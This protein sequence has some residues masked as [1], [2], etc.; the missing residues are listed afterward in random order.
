MT[1]FSI[2]SPQ[3]ARRASTPIGR[4]QRRVDFDMT[5]D[6]LQS[7][8]PQVRF[9]AS[10]TK[11]PLSLS[12]LAATPSND[13]GVDRNDGEFALLA[14]DEVILPR[15]SFRTCVHVNSC[16]KVS[17]THYFNHSLQ[18]RIRIPGSSITDKTIER[19]ENANQPV[20]LSN[21]SFG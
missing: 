9:L 6:L 2:S 11:S 18:P 4:P 12:T 20:A 7:R 16:L 10:W 21:S 15:R 3:A 8:R 5:G 14:L 19:P 13:P 1:T 17:P